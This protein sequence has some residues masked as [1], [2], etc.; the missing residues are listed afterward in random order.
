MSERIH[1]HS[2]SAPHSHDHG[3]AH[4]HGPP[5]EG[6]TRAF[7]I[8]VVLN[9][10]IVVLEA[11]YGILAHSMA[12]LADAGHNLGD[13]LGLVLAGGATFLA[14]RRPT[15]R[16]TY[17]YRRVTLL[18]ALANG[19]FLLV[20]VGAIAG[21]SI[22]RFDAPRPVAEHAVIAVAAIAAVV[23]GLSALPFAGHGTRDVNVRA[24]YLHLAGD[25]G[26]SVA[27]VVGALVMLRTGW[28]WID[29]ALSLT[30]AALIL[31]STWSLFRRSLNLVLDAV[32]EGIDI[33]ALREYLAGLPRVREV[34]DLHVW[35]LSTTETALTA[36]LVMP[37]S[38]CGPTFL[39]DVCRELHDRFEINHPTLQVDPEDAPDP[40][41]LA[42]E[43]TL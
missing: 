27:V 40:C 34:H 14:R 32:P 17:G 4:A 19:I 30:V 5:P 3:H 39:S 43:E 29:P 12:L 26:I 13:V 37:A 42:P 35:P 18:S 7:A 6:V 25:A 36:H 15:K 16:R 21:E 31:A 22:R 2:H 9:L 41:K 23:N 38:A 28:L 10:G 1:A 24:A 11:V 8:G 33:D 20:A